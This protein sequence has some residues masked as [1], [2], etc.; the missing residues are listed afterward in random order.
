MLNVAGQPDPVPAG[1]I[2]DASGLEL[3]AAF[4]PDGATRLAVAA[5]CDDGVR[6]FGLGPPT[7]RPPAVTGMFVGTSSLEQNLGH[8][9]VVPAGAAVD[10]ASAPGT[11]AGIPARNAFPDR[12]KP[13]CGMGTGG[14]SDLG[15]TAPA[16]FWSRRPLPSR[17][18][19]PMPS[20]SPP[21]AA[22]RRRRYDPSSTM[23]L[24]ERCTCWSAS[25]TQ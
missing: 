2:D 20:T 16:P 8:W 1:R 6:T 24:I 15:S 9:C 18:G 21:P 14:G 5:H 7:N 13:T 25:S 4:E 11:V 23:T 17:P 22:S 10:A 19:P 12:Q 3:Y